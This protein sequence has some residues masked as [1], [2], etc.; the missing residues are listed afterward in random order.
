MKCETI[1]NLVDLLKTIKNKN[2]LVKTFVKE[3]NSTKEIKLIGNKNITVEQ[4][5]KIL[6]GKMEQAGT[7]ERP[8]ET[9]RFMP[10][11]KVGNEITFFKFDSFKESKN[12]VII[13]LT[14]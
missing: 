8:C 6:R 5:I 4:F 9:L 13:N 12:E 14:T 1:K 2:S 7:V 10:F 3:D 11:L